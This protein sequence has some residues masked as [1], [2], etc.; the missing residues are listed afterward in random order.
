MTFTIIKLHVKMNELCKNLTKTRCTWYINTTIKYQ[1]GLSFWFNLPISTS[2][3][4][5]T[6]AQQMPVFDRKRG[7]EYKMNDFIFVSWLISY[8]IYFP[9]KRP[10]WM[11][12]LHGKKKGNYLKICCA[13]MFIIY[14]MVMS[15]TTRTKSETYFHLK[16]K[17]EKAT[18]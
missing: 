13:L 7:V 17:G 9:F 1:Q 16:K 12:N 3:F 10:C 11:P 15:R 8:I 5:F 18:R 6:V 14:A 2:Y 4:A